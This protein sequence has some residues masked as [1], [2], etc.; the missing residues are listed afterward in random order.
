MPIAMGRLQAHYNKTYSPDELTKISTMFGITGDMSQA[1]AGNLRG[2]FEKVKCYVANYKILVAYH[3]ITANTQ[4]TA[5]DSRWG[6]HN[7][8]WIGECDEDVVGMLGPLER[9]ATG[10][11]T[12]DADLTLYNMSEVLSTHGEGLLKA[13]Q[14]YHKTYKSMLEK[15]KPT[16]TGEK[17]LKLCIQVAEAIEKSSP[18]FE[19]GAEL[20]GAGLEN[21][22][23]LM[24]AWV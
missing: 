3:P 9:P 13:W 14:E 18:I 10:E 19:G 24:S 21:M 2:H 4:K 5:M 15:Y 8:V 6:W 11:V 23:T 20:V 22:A 7:G 12:L 16:A 1:D 17:R